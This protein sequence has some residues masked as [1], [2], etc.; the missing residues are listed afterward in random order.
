M[1]ACVCVSVCLRVFMCVCVSVCVRMHLCSSVC[2]ILSINR[3]STLF[4][5]SFLH[6]RA[7]L[8]LG[9]CVSNL[10]L[11]ICVYCIM[12]VVCYLMYIVLPKLGTLQKNGQIW[13][14]FFACQNHSEVL[15]HVL[16]Q[17]GG[18]I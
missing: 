17:G 3:F 12:H 7:R 14:L 16:Q 1:C 13:E 8:L 15:K 2:H 18:V 9:P 4:H 11:C 6:N 5:F 10:I